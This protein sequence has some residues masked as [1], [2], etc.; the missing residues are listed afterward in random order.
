MAHHDPAAEA[1]EL[2]RREQLANDPQLARG[3]A[4][5][6]ADQNNNLWR[7]LTEAVASVNLCAPTA[8]ASFNLRRRYDRAYANM[9]E[10]A[11]QV[12]LSNPEHE[13]VN[14]PKFIEPPMPTAK[15]ET[16]LTAADFRSSDMYM[17]TGGRKGGGVAPGIPG[18]VG[19]EAWLA[20]QGSK[21]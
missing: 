14:V 6:R 13:A 18:S 17:E 9:R 3:R 2:R 8:N 15:N 7:A 19:E 1:A 12:I 10:C 11:R 16:T 21:K 20:V 5:A 4:Q